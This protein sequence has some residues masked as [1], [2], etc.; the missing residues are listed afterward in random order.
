MIRTLLLPNVSLWGCLWQ[1]TLF[2]ILGL[3]GSFLLR[4]RPARA[5]QVLLL[6]VMAAV[7][8]PVLSGV[9]RHFN[10]GIFA[11]QVTVPELDGPHESVA[12]EAG[13]FVATSATIGPRGFGSAPRCLANDRPVDLG[14]GNICPVRATALCVHRWSLSLPPRPA[15]EQWS[16]RTSDESRQ[17]KA[18]GQQGPANTD[19]HGRSESRDLVLGSATRPVV[20]RRCEWF[21]GR[22]R[23]EGRDIP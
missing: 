17:S 11:R 15:S 16:G 21:R 18:G 8:V 3:A 4:R 23:L 22:N 7:L 6:A 9:V 20:A 19:R 2:A 10:L 12:M 1:S 14:G 13:A 5:H